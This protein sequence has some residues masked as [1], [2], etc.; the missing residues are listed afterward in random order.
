M[1]EYVNLGDKIELLTELDSQGNQKKY[2]SSIQGVE[3][4]T[5]IV[6]APM[7]KGRIEPL[8]IMRV[9]GMCI[10]TDKGLYRAEVE[11]VSREVRETLFLLHVQL[12]SE[13]EKFQR[14]QF[15]RMDC[16]LQFNFK[17]VNSDDDW[18]NALILDISGGGIRFYTKEK[19]K[20]GDEIIN[21]IKLQFKDRVEELYLTGKVL[22][23]DISGKKDD[24]KFEVR[25]V[26]EDIDEDDREVIIKYIFDEERRRRRKRKGSVR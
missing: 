6:S 13:L 7:T 26:F 8:E 11:V 24:I 23:M 15:Y 5:L 9:Y 17:G 19:L 2:F 18:F 10:Y 1:L 16:V 25:E 3:G 4:N 14:R 12:R 22:S 21:H 20:I